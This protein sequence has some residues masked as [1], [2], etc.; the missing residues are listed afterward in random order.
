MLGA[1]GLD[2]LAVAARHGDRWA[3][4]E[5]VRGTQRDVLR[6]CHALA[7]PDAAEDVAQETYERALRSLPRWRG[8]APVRV[9]LLSIARRAC[10]DHVR[11]AVR[12]RRVVGALRRP[13]ASA[14]V[15][16]VSDVSGAHA[17]SDLLGGLDADRR[18]A[19]VLTQVVGLTY[20][21]AARVCGCA[22]GTIRS[23]VSRARDQ[24]IDAGQAAETA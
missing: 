2:D 22:V 20:E 23:R 8:E 16:A 13:A 18:V 9:W 6:L 19:F 12:R 14:S 4:A 1:G 17:L 10:A 5:L 21:E 24:L 7:G 15:S 11:K 3:L